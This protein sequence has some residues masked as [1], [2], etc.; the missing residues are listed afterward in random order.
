MMKNHHH[1]QQDAQVQGV[2]L[3]HHQ[4]HQEVDLGVSSNQASISTLNI[5]K[6]ILL[7]QEKMNISPKMND[8]INNTEI[9][10]LYYSNVLNK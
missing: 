1:E 4:H 3:Q 6:E 10:L 9:M 2:D 8:V 5:Q 7:L